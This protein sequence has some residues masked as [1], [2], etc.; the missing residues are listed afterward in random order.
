MVTG[1]ARGV[2][3]AA[4]HL[5]AAEGA[6][7]V[8]TD[9]LGEEL[10]SHARPLGDAARV[11][12][13]DLR[14]QSDVDGVVELAH[15]AFGGIDV[16]FNNAGVTIRRPVTDTD[17][18]TWETALEINLRSAFWLI[19]AASPRMITRRSGSIINNASI[20]AMRGNV[21]LAAYSAAKGGLVALT[22]AVATELAP[23]GI[24][25]NALCPGTVESP[26]TDEYLAGVD[27]ADEL[28]RALV[29]KHP[30]GR[31]ASVDD[32]A[33]AALFLASDEA[34]FITGVALPVDGGR[35]LL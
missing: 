8:G 9:L 19:R 3:R 11:L 30:L 15:E 21:D 2:G 13:G 22:R 10:E 20:N 26:M 6:K 31:L 18:E 28:R 24:R 12:A 14:S 17:N 7:V 27:S 33:R 32:I 29:A 5:F 16:V 1:A 35:H 4:L 25:V 23:H 34:A